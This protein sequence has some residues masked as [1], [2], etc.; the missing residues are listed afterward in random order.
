M[1]AACVMYG[2]GERDAYRVLVGKLVRKRPRAG[3]R[4]RWRIILK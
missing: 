2:G 1:G 3:P 4:R